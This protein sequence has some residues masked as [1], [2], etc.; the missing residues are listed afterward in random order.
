MTKP[1]ILIADD[2]KDLV[3][4]L[5]QRCQ[6]LGLVVVTAERG[7]SAFG[8]VLE[9]QPDIICLDVNMP[10]GNGM[11]ICEMLAEDPNLKSI[12]RIMLT[13]SSEPAIIRRCH[14]SCAYYVQKCPDVWQRIQ[15]LLCELLHLD[16]A[17]PEQADSRKVQPARSEPVGTEADSNLLDAVFA[18]LGHDAAA[19]ESPD[20]KDSSPKNDSVWILHIEDDRELSSALSMRLRPHGVAVIPAFSGMEGYR[21]AFL[22]PA[23]AIILDMELPNGNGDY[24]MRRLKETPATKDIPVIVLTGRKERASERQMINLGADAYLT[25]PLNFDE[26]LAVLEQI[27]KLDG[28]RLKKRLPADGQLKSLSRSAT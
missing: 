22:N 9:H 19:S 13:G 21:R 11:H 7:L 28:K 3:N 4:V 1:C 15:P 2:D 5:T 24:V 25:K 8:A 17:G 14:E 27:V 6:Q 12:P 26:L 23:S 10:A 16:P 18:M 20:A